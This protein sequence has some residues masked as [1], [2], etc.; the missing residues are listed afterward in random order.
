MTSHWRIHHGVNTWPRNHVEWFIFTEIA[1][2]QGLL[3]KTSCSVYCILLEAMSWLTPGWFKRILCSSHEG[4]THRPHTRH[5]QGYH[6]A[7]LCLQI[8]SH[9][10]SF[11]PQSKKL[12]AREP[13]KRGVAEDT[14]RTL[15]VWLL[16]FPVL[17][18]EPRVLCILSL[19]HAPS[20][21]ASLQRPV[22]KR[23]HHN[24]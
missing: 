7:L 17:A 3:G 11:I 9:R 16:C 23:Y 24:S 20:Q 2:R 21:G 14:E 6:L 8:P 10:L 19:I 4:P 15:K 12:Q 1:E 13:V 22:K 18:M 5:V